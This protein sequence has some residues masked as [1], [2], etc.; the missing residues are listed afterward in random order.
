MDISQS[1]DKP[2]RSGRP[3]AEPRGQK[4]FNVSDAP[5]HKR[6]KTVPM[7]SSSWDTKEVGYFKP[8][9]SH[10]HVQDIKGILYFSHVIAFLNHIRALSVFKDEDTI[11]LNLHTCLRGTAL[12]W[13]ISELSHEH[14]ESPRDLPLEEGWFKKLEDRFKPGVSESL[15][16]LDYMRS[17]EMEHGISLVTWQ[18]EHGI[19]PVFWAH[20]AL[21]YLQAS[22]SCSDVSEQLYEIWEFLDENYEEWKIPEPTSNTSI[23]DFMRS[24]DDFYARVYENY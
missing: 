13:F 16:K 19:S 23:P 17:L 15:E 8:C 18:M 21:R 9:P 3:S 20:N 11:R 22:G 10:K 14:R 6:T 1:P 7:K 5:L 4:R 12:E 24:L 2:S